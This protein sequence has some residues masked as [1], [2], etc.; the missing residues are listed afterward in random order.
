MPPASTTNKMSDSVIPIKPYDIRF[1]HRPGYLYVF[2][3]GEH[4]S[5]AISR[6]YWQEIADVCLEDS[7]N[8]VL[9]EEDIVE[10]ISMSDVFKLV[11]GLG[12]M[13]FTGKKIAFVDRQLDHAALNDFGVLVG[14]NRGLL[15]QAFANAAEAEKWLLS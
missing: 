5:F 9:V 15:A 13:G 6:Q 1:E 8:K 7:I 11:S 14:V 4:D 12:Q 10:V 3:E 2:V